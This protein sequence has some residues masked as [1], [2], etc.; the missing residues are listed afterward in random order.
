MSINFG[1][2]MNSTPNSIK[3]TLGVLALATIVSTGLAINFYKKSAGFE[4]DIYVL[5]NPAVITESEVKQIVAD[6]GQMIVLP[7]DESPT[8]ATV[9]DP[10][11]LKDQAFFAHALAGDKVLV[12]TKAQKAVLWRPSI[13]KV[14]EVSGLNTAPSASQTVVATTSV[15]TTIKAPV[16]AKK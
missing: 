7:T 2:T 12:Y 4:R 10:E 16:P 14:I 9:S 15:P 6:V 8:L 13:K 5:K 1:N 3:I 11:K